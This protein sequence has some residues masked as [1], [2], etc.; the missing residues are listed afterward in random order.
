M[1]KSNKKKKK[2]KKDSSSESSEEESSEEESSEES[3]EENSSDDSDSDDDSDDSDDS[4]K[5]G[6]EEESESEEDSDELVEIRD[7][8]LDYIAT[9]DAHAIRKACKGFG[10]NEKSLID[11]LCVR[12]YSQIAAVGVIFEKEYGM[13]LR[14][15]IKKECSGDFGKLLRFK[16]EER[17]KLD[18]ELLFKAM[19]GVGTNTSVLTEIICCRS[20]AELGKIKT[21]FQ[22]RY[23]KT[24]EEWVADEFSS[25]W[26]GDYKKI[27]EDMMK[28]TRSQDPVANEALA[29]EQAKKLFDAVNKTFGKDSKV[30][31][32]IFTKS[33]Q[34][35]M[36]SIKKYFDQ[37][38]GITLEA[39]VRKFSG[40][41][42]EALLA[43][44]E[45]PIWFYSRALKNAFK[46]LGT[47]EA[48]VVRILAGNSRTDAALVRDRF[49]QLY[50]RP[51]V[52]ALKSEISGDFLKAAT[53]SIEGPSPT[54]D[55]L[56]ADEQAYKD[57][58]EEG[59][60]TQVHCLAS[61]LARMDAK[62]IRKAC[63]GFG[64][65]DEALTEILCS[66][67]RRH[68]MRVDVI[69]QVLT[70]NRESGRHLPGIDW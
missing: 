44:L 24:L 36:D 62:D 12:T 70:G 10:T 15:Q 19:K 14:Q 31:I 22:T 35:Q 43:L 5:S 7:G 45:D 51:L 64:T 30:F 28:C 56:E 60:R 18:A 66:R 13:T 25:M 50:G 3:S 29:S 48:A 47:D 55:N 46:G 39:A 4:D 26:S 58:D 42:K 27:L 67:T 16:L 8:L 33:S 1:G 38:H 41:V 17:Y 20:N 9:K 32:E 69:Y 57:L 34:A 59:L 65:D 6:D 53:A 23:Q 49:Q 52:D 40:K 2:K 61:Y 11:I 21:E 68:L 63:K 54:G 37:N